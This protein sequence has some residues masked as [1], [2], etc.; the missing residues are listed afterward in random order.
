TS[1]GPSEPKSYFSIAAVLREAAHSRPRSDEERQEMIRHSVAESV[2]YHLVSDV[3]VGAFLSSGRDSSTVVALA[4]EAGPPLRTVTLRFEEYIGTE[5]DEA[6]LAEVIARQYGTQHETRTLTGAEFRDTLPKALEAMDQPS[7]DGM[8]SYFVCK[9]AAELGWK[10][11]LSGT[12]GDELFGWYTTFRT[13]P[14]TVRAFRVF[15]YF[16]SFAD[17]YGRTYTKLMPKRG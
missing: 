10:V 6:P 17:F 14:R 15:R 12:G 4:A 11:A 1:A 7:I 16:P 3:P 9:A 2:R 13:I 5:R 8:N